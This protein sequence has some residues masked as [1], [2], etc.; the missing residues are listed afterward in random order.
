LH[1][2][3]Q[4]IGADDFGSAVANA[5]D[6]NNDGVPDIIV[7]AE[8]A[9]QSAPGDAY[10]F[11]G[12]DWSVLHSFQG[13]GNNG[14]FGRSVSGAGDVN[15]DGFDDVMVGAP[16]PFNNSNPGVVRVFSGADGSILYTFNGGGARGELFGQSIA[17]A[18]DLNGDS[19]PD[20]IIGAYDEGSGNLPGAALV[21]MSVATPAPAVCEGDING[22]GAVNFADLNAVLSRF[23]LM[24]P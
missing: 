2:F 19:H 20:L 23:G 9:G 11:S 22:D 12:A 14:L 6:V 5:G 18:G 15:A 7:G 24:C 3:Q 17:Y 21:I 16:F 4:P 10:V 8:A 13:A 1:T